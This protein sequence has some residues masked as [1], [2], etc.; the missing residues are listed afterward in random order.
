MM[1]REDQLKITKEDQVNKRISD[2]D[3]ERRPSDL[4]DDKRRLAE[5]QIT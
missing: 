5:R 2:E 3:Y 1:T 4:K